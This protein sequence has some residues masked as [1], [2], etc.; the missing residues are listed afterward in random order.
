MMVTFEG[1]DESR[2]FIYLSF[3]SRS[4]QREARSYETL[5]HKTDKELSVPYR[6]RL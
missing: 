6:L 4:L 3:I 1:L 5:S 2:N